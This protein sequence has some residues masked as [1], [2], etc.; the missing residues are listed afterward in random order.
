MSEIIAGVLGGAIGFFASF[1]T[2]RFQYRQ[3][4]ARTV[5]ENRMDWIN[6]FREELSVIVAV[7]RRVG[8]RNANG[9]FKQQSAGS[10][11]DVILEAEQ[12]RI[13]LL[14]RLNQDVEKTGNEFNGVFEQ[15][16]KAIDFAKGI[17]QGEF[18][19]LLDIARKI[20]EF[21]WRRVKEEAKGEEKNV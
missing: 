10:E 2:L 4:F 7:S 19:E 8:D 9:K 18:D 13:K 5:S 1:L 14:T 20:L 15:K 16:L 21:E 3:L 17:T 6:R 12:A 11:S